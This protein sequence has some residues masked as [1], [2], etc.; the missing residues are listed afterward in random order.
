MLGNVVTPDRARV[1]AMQARFPF[2]VRLTADVLAADGGAPM[3][4]VSLKRP[5][6]GLQR[7]AAPA[8][9]LLVLNAAA[10]A[11]L[12]RF[13]FTAGPLWKIWSPTA[14]PVESR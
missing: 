5:V 13:L 8:G 3:A 9:A 12:Y 1:R 6:P 2:A 4:A 14:A 10:V 7:L 11:G